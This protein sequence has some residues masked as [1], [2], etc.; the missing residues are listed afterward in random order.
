MQPV[1]LTNSA[2]SRDPITETCRDDEIPS[3]VSTS[4]STFSEEV[5]ELFASDCHAVSGRYVTSGN[6]VDRKLHFGVKTPRKPQILEPRCQISNQI[7]TH[8]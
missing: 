4:G 3:S 7:N 2:K 6:R 5:G 1:C 8:E